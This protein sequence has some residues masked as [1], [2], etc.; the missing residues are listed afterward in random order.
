MVCRLA[1]VVADADAV[2]VSSPPSGPG[3]RI[4]G[5]AGRFDDPAQQQALQFVAGR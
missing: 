3:L 5:S 4:G 1:A 2:L